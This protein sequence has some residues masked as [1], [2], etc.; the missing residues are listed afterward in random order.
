MADKSGYRYAT[1]P[2]KPDVEYPNKYNHILIDTYDEFVKVYTEYMSMLPKYIAFD[3]ETTG[4]NYETLDMVGFSF[5]FTKYTG[6]Y[7]PLKHSIGVNIDKQQKVIDMMLAMLVASNEV[8]VYNVRFDRR[9][10]KKSISPKYIKYIENIKWFDVSLLVHLQDTNIKETSLKWAEGHYLG[11]K[12]TTFAELT[13]GTYTIYH[14]DPKEVTRYAVDDALGTYN[15]YLKLSKSREQLKF[16]LELDNEFTKVIEDMEDSA[17]IIDLDLVEQVQSQ[18]EKLLDDTVERLH[19]LV[20]VINLG[21]PAQISKIFIDKYLHLIPPNKRK[22]ILKYGKTGQLSLGVAELEKVRPYMTDNF[23]DDLL[24]YRKLSKIISTYTSPFKKYY[25]DYIQGVRFQYN[26]INTPTGRLSC[27]GGKSKQNP[28]ELYFAKINT[29]AIPKPIPADFVLATDYIG[30][31]SKKDKDN[32]VEVMGY[33]FVEL[34]EEELA[35]YDHSVVIEGQTKYSNL[36]AA[37]LAGNERIWVSVDF[38][39]CELVLPAI[40]SNEPIYIETFKKKGDPHKVVAIE[41]WGAEQYNKYV[42]KRA[43]VMNFSCLYGGS[44][45]SLYMMLGCTIKEADVYIAKWW[46]T[47]KVLRKWVFLQQYD[48]IQ[49][50]WCRTFFGRPRNLEYYLNSSRRNLKEFGK[51]SVISHI[52]QGSA[53]DV[54]KICGIRIRNYAKQLGLAPDGKPYIDVKSTIHDEFNMTLH[55]SISEIHKVLAHIKKLM[56]YQYKDWPVALECSI[57]IGNTWGQQFDIEKINV[58]DKTM[59]F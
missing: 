43:K 17:T 50:G 28:D 23:I 33:T 21:S 25:K 24:T 45:R 58:E 12:A 44:G 10:L 3:T 18:N 57:S 22:S 27:S 34:T 29:Q 39:A 36:R 59:E 53:S 41:M 56:T 47:L 55:T 52:V 38:S 9:V 48:A 14:L 49:T 11:W 15:L 1:P 30:D 5:N 8:Y 32:I 31:L 20:G 46:D 42:R 37:Y 13:K 16:V 6:Y 4:L 7:I 26:N 35:Q 19:S 40:F 2:A 51:R 54:M